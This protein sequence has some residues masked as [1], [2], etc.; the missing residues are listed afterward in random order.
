MLW[1]IVGIVAAWVVLG[2][3]AAMWIG[4]VVRHADAQES[5]AES[6]RRARETQPRD[7]AA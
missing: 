4:R 6:R 3:V 5:A 2:T 7:D 1:W